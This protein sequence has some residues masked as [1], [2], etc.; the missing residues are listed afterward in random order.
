MEKEKVSISVLFCRVYVDM[1]Q[2][3]K[4]KRMLKILKV[5]CFQ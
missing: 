1:I 2:D 4:H 3:V 5:K